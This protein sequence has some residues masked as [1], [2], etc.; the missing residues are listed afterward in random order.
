MSLKI[1]PILNLPNDSIKPLLVVPICPSSDDK[2]TKAPLLL[3]AT[4]NYCIAFSSNC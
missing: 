3:K 1:K 2:L 4:Q